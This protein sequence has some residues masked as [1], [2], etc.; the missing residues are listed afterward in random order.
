MQK[1]KFNIEG[2]R[3]IIANDFTVE[4][5]AR[6]ASAI[7]KWLLRKYKTPT[8]V[9]GYDTRFGGEMF[10]ET[11][12]KIL[13]V[14]GIRV[15]I[16]EDF[17]PSPVVS[18]GVIRLSANCGIY[19]SAS[20][21]PAEFNGIK[22]KDAQGAPVNLRELKDIEVLIPAEP[23]IDY[24][25]ISW[26][27]ML[28]QQMI[29]YINLEN[30]YQKE[31]QE[32]FNL[33]AIKTVAKSICID[34]MFGSAQRIIHKFLGQH[35]IMNGEVNPTFKGRAP[36]P[37]IKNMTA[38]AT[39]IE[40]ME[41]YQMGIA[42]DGDAD[43]LAIIDESGSVI[44]THHVILLLIHY[45]AG[46]KKLAGKVIL[47]YPVTNRAETLC[48][49]YGIE[50]ERVNIGFA[51]ISNA[52]KKEAILLGAE[53]NGGIVINNHVHDRDAIWTTMVFLEM[54]VNTGKSVGQLMQEIYSITGAFYN[55]AFSVKMSRK[56][57]AGLLENAGSKSQF[58][59]KYRVT[60]L[61]DKE[62][63]R[64]SDNGNVV[65]IRPSAKENALRI[66]VES[67]SQDKLQEI[68]ADWKKGI[69]NTATVTK[70]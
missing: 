45:L 4:N 18:T 12:A 25:I 32:N 46:Y 5:I 65:I 54:L 7:A 13:A 66:Y 28:N 62:V 37:E 17:V 69:N 52:M 63:V 23:D 26:N 24:Q 59:E 49:H 50:I 41:Q 40:A 9:L 10:M 2:W 48:G 29:Q 22:I 42:M 51:E 67:D 39:R 55:I 27:S 21:Y 44:D 57:I 56:S 68:M 15:F 47:S 19:I 70:V 30:I 1:I 8:V 16:P 58:S 33:D 34:A 36:N 11:I 6:I 31:I 3:G 14:K 64:F 61:I 53:S 60:E 38:L 35:Q 20:H 43:R